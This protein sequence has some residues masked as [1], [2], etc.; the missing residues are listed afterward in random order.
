M[1]PFEFNTG[2]ELTFLQ[3]GSVFLLLPRFF[4]IESVE[5]S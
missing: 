3:R 5:T 4:R 1:E 2:V